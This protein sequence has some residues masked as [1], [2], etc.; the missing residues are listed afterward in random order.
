MINLRRV[1]A[2]ALL[3]ILATRG[4]SFA[5]TP[6]ENAVEW[7]LLG[8]WKLDC[9]QPASRADPELTYVTRHGALFHDRNFGSTKDSNRVLSATTTTSGGIEILVRFDPPGQT[10]QWTSI[11]RADGRLQTTSNRNVDNDEYSIRHGRFVANGQDVPWQ[12]RC[13]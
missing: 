7:G 11:K 4:A 12:T 3:G 6:A 8:M 9:S 13:R 2:F 5:Q 1:L 10:R